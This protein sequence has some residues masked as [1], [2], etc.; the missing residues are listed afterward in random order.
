[1]PARTGVGVLDERGPDGP[2]WTA[3]PARRTQ[4]EGRCFDGLGDFAVASTPRWAAAS[5]I[6]G[7]GWVT[8]PWPAREITAQ[9]STAPPTTRTSQAVAARAKVRLILI[10]ASSQP[11]AARANGPPTQTLSR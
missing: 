5:P 9:T 4:T 2:E 3:R 6:A 8:T 7:P 1:M 11:R 10:S